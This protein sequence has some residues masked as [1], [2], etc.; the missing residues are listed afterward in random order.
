MKSYRIKTV[1]RETGLSPELLRAWER[2]YK[3]VR[4]RRGK[5]GYREYTDQDLHRLRML[6]DLTSAGYTISEIAS[7]PTAELQRL[8]P[9]EEEEA[10]PEPGPVQRLA[11]S[12]AQLDAELRVE[13][14][15]MLALLPLQ[16]AL[17]DV[18]RPLLSR[19][20]RDAGRGP[21]GQAAWLFALAEIRGALA[22]LD[23]PGD[24]APVALVAPA[25]V[26]P[27]PA[28]LLEAQLAAV[29]AGFRSILIEGAGSD[30]LQRLAHGT[31]AVFVCLVFGPNVGSAD[32]KALL[33]R[34]RAARPAGQKLVLVGEGVELFRPL[35]VE[36]GYH[37][38][39]DATQ[40]GDLLGPW[41]DTDE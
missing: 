32:F 13:L 39:G 25:P 2:R 5:G 15:R 38:A 36:L 18:V 7:L 9:D 1:S 23:P 11:H 30:E 24:G 31:S 41:S 17:E 14:R 28:D 3:V 37:H 29:G 16:E 10:A 19:L 40:L 6:R 35:I 27:H 21:G 22:L 34:W 33:D 8:M 20:R 12:A 4:P 26:A